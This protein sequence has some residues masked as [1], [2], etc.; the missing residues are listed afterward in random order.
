[1]TL[2]TN[3]IGLDNNAGLCFVSLKSCK[4]QVS[5]KLL[6]ISY[7]LLH[8]TSEEIHSSQIKVSKVSVNW[9]YNVMHCKH[10]APYLKKP[11]KKKSQLKLLITCS[12][13]DLQR[14][15]TVSLFVFLYLGVTSSTRKDDILDYARRTVL[16]QLV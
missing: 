6:H 3:D 10:H 5:C 9:F 7:D 14:Y 13:V 2:D 12:A 11:F 16:M 1:M 4:M 15:K 8:M